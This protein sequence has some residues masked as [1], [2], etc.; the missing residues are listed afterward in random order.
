VTEIPIALDGIYRWVAFLPS[1]QDERMSVAN[2]YVAVG[3][4]GEIKM[5][6]IETRRRDTPPFIV[7]AQLEML[8]VLA[9]TAAREEM[10]A[11][12][13]EV[14]E[15]ACSYADALKSGQVPYQDL[16]IT[17]RLSRDPMTYSKDTLLAIAAKELLNAGVELS[18]GESI[19]YIITE[20][21]AQ[22]KSDRAQPLV[23][24]RGR[25]P[26]DAEKYVELL[27][28][29]VETVLAPLGVRYSQIEQWVKSG[30]GSTPIKVLAPKSLGPLFDFAKQKDVA[31]SRGR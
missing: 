9:A 19:Q 20:E 16:V 13:P 28:R 21:H 6:G 29:A 10:E 3:E 14:I 4:D 8:K 11:L 23:H 18:P 22:S 26:Y 7:A 17:K 2:R 31:L 24:Y 12:I 30:V 25:E 5:R 15:V 1:R 27:L